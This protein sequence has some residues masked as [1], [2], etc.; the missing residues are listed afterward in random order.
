MLH[1]DAH[2][3]TRKVLDKP[4][5][6]IDVRQ[7]A[8]CAK[9][10]CAAEPSSRARTKTTHTRTHLLRKWAGTC[11]H[12]YFEKE[13]RTFVCE[14]HN[15]T[16]VL[17]EPCSTATH[18]RR[19]IRRDN[20]NTQNQ[21]KKRHTNS[22]NLNQYLCHVRHA[23][24]GGE[25][26]LHDHQEE[27]RHPLRRLHRGQENRPA[28]Q[29]QVGSLLLDV[30][31]RLSEPGGQQEVHRPLHAPKSPEE[32]EQQSHMDWVRR[33]TP[34]ARPQN[35]REPR[36]K[37]RVF[38]ATSFAV[39]CPEEKKCRIDPV[40]YIRLASAKAGRPSRWGSAVYASFAA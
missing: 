28:H 30:L 10:R 24:G 21:L 18:K 9:G 15:R 6:L 39:N 23:L 29:R 17:S 32:A 27:P 26:G 1:T 38:F 11:T 25:G 40:R 37:K 31:V 35:T 12:A 20:R 2:P 33:H 36:K 34:P 4:L 3:R 19:N 22:T 13:K 7:R 16:Y 8:V 14:T 5:E